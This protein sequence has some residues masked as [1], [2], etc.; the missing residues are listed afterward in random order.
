MRCP[1]GLTLEQYFRWQMPD[2]PP[3]SGCWEWPHKPEVGQ[4]AGYGQIN[5]EEHHLRAYVL[6]YRLHHG[7]IPNGMVVRHECNNPICVHPNHLLLGTV[8]DNSQDMI[9]AGNSTRGERSHMAKL[10]EADVV[11]IRREVAQGQIYREIAARYGV[12]R[13]AIS[14][15][16]NGSTWSHVDV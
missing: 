3:T 12:S 11:K 1:S 6:S 14:H 13:R 2:D 9:L 4:R 16:A 5:Y 15:I 8:A 10:T 7:D